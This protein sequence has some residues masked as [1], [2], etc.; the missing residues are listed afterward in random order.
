MIVRYQIPH[1][2]T[3]QASFPWREIPR[4]RL[5]LGKILGEGEF[6]MVVIGELTEDDG[7]VTSCAV[8]KLK[9]MFIEL[10][11]TPVAVAFLCQ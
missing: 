4:D 1:T 11:L 9:R 8:K 7:H 10:M 3:I 6:G 2:S 5:T